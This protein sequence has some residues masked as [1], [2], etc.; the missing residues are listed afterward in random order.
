[1]SAYPAYT[2]AAWLAEGVKSVHDGDTIHATLDLGC[3]VCIN[4]TIRFYGV[5]APELGT[6]EGKVAKAWVLEWFAEHC[7]DDRF[8]LETVKDKREKY[9]RYLGIVLPLEGEGS[10]NDALVAAGQAVKYLPK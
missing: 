9:G 5:N 10:L 8:V 6:P 3:D 2:Y 4:L 1:M 7:P